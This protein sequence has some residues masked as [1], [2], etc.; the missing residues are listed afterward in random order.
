MRRGARLLAA[1]IA[2]ALASAGACSRR[3]DGTRP[4]PVENLPELTLR[5]ETP[6]LLLTWIDERGAAHTEV[7]TTD[8]PAN[9]RSLVRVVLADRED[10]TRDRF[11]VADLSTKRPDG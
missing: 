8:V 5:D 1:A 10:G 3:D 7:H 6:N 2:I 11:Y 9:G 4:E